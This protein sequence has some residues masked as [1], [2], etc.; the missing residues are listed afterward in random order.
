MCGEEGIKKPEQSI[1]FKTKKTS[2]LSPKTILSEFE[3]QANC[4]NPQKIDRLVQLLKTILSQIDFSPSQFAQM[5]L[6]SS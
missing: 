1:I 3:K 6:D 5:L 4:S 2:A